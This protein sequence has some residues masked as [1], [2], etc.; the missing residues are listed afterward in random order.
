MK[1][2]SGWKTYLVVAIGVIFNGLVAMGYVD[3]SLRPTVNS[4]LTFLGLGAMR[5]AINKVK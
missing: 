2:L 5:D 1:L 4:I 3:E